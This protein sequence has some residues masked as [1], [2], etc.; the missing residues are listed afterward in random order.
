MISAAMSVIV[1][2]RTGFLAENEMRMPVQITIK[3][4]QNAN[5]PI[6]PWMDARTA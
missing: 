1:L 4:N 2:M 6:E 3:G 5:R